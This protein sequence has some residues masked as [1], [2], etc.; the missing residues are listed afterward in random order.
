MPKKEVGR[1]IAARYQRE[2][3]SSDN[4]QHFL[5]SYRILS[6][7]QKP[8][9]FVSLSTQLQGQLHTPLGSCYHQNFYVIS[10]DFCYFGILNFEN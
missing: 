5:R 4:N 8:E 1:K 10:Y 6:M 3:D 2:L 7:C 9:V